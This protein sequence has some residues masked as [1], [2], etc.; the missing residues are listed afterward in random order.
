MSIVHP[1]RRMKLPDSGGGARLRVGGAVLAVLCVTIWGTARGA[2]GAPGPDDISP[3]LRALLEAEIRHLESFELPEN[4]EVEYIRRQPP[5]S[6]SEEEHADLVRL[7][8]VEANAR[9]QLDRYRK[10]N[11]YG[12]NEATTTLFYA[13]AS[14]WRTN[15]DYPADTVLSY[16]DY[17]S[18]KDGIWL[19]NNRQMQYSAGHEPSDGFYPASQVELLTTWLGIASTG[20]PWPLTRTLHLVEAEENGSGVVFVLRDGDIQ[21]RRT[22]LTGVIED[23]LGSSPGERLIIT[24]AE[25][26]PSEGAPFS[27]TSTFD[28]WRREE[29]F[30]RKIAHT[31]TVHDEKGREIQATTLARVGP[32][33][34]DI[35]A[36]TR[37]PTADGSDPF[38]GSP[39]FASVIDHSGGEIAYVNTDDRSLLG[40]VPLE[41]RGARGWK[42]V[43]VLAAVAAVCAVL[44]IHN[45]LKPSN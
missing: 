18:G 43:G 16:N 37:R 27:V 35:D 2:A 4:I 7:A 24:K 44:L 11:E 6:L 45:R 22:R 23:A 26:S 17:G 30:G 31:M 34:H 36:I 13:D 3:R 12:S 39:T 20:I 28:D 1:I 19:L 8:G 33:S 29:A 42:V 40:A 10:E 14:R 32:L 21:G 38:R 9:M 41:K 15:T 25:V 5:M